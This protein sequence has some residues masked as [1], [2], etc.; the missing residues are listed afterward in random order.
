MKT[1]PYILA[2]YRD[3]E[4]SLVEIVGCY[5]TVSDANCLFFFLPWMYFSWLEIL[6][7]VCMFAKLSLFAPQSSAVRDSS[8]ECVSRAYFDVTSQTSL[9]AGLSMVKTFFVMVLLSAGS[10]MFTR[11]AT[12]M[13][14]EPIERMVCTCPPCYA[15]LILCC[16]V[17][18]FVLYLLLSYVNSILLVPQVEV[19]NALAKDP[20]SQH[21][22]KSSDGE[23]GGNYETALLEATLAKIGGLLQ[24][25]FGEAG[26]EII[27]KNMSGGGELDPMIPGKKMTA[28]FGFCDIRQFTDTTECLQEE[29]MVYVNKIG[30]IVHECTSIYYG[31]PNKN[32]GDAFLLAW[33]VADGDLE[34]ENRWAEV[35]CDARDKFGATRKITVN[36]MADSALAA[37]LKIIVDLDNANQETAERHGCLAE[38]GR[39]PA[40]LDRFGD[41]FQVSHVC[42]R[43][44][45]LLVIICTNP[46]LFVHC[47]T[48][49]DGL[50]H[51]HWLGH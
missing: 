4:T 50:R 42:C 10:V 46:L 48:D 14:I 25:G 34:K 26:A 40:V 47:T 36:E 19:V 29:V 17:F 3:S 21:K 1:E 35:L 8:A 49:Q 13:V 6:S 43:F 23:E 16:T 38:Y 18:D 31:A 44:C 45:W 15:P 28:I 30:Q 2:N 37:F 5:N 22:K 33:K 12:K 9:E 24:V 11:D 32:I 51:A 27:G 7:R 39:H 20:L 41:S